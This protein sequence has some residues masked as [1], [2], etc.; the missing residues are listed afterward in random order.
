[1]VLPLL[2]ALVLAVSACQPAPVPA[3]S[4]APGEAA[5]DQGRTAYPH[6]DERIG[7]PRQIWDGVLK[8]DR[9][10]ATFRNTHRL[11]PTR[12]VSPAAQPRPL[13]AGPALT[14]PVITHDGRPLAFEELLEANR[15]AGLLVLKDGAVVLE[16]YRYGNTPQTRWMSMSVAKSVL[17]ALTGAALHDGRLA[18]LDEPVTRFVPVLQGSAYDGVTFDHLLRMASGVRFNEAYT[19]RTS[20]RRRMLE[21]QIAQRRGSIMGL[22]ASLPRDAEPGTRVQYSTGETQVLAGAARRGRD[23]AGD[24]LEQRIWQPAGME[25]PALWWLD[26]PDGTEIGGSGLNATLRDYGRFGQ[27]ILEDGV[28]GETRVLPEGWARRMGR[29]HGML[30]GTEIPYGL[31]WWPPTTTLAMAHGAFTAEGIHGQFIHVDPVARVVIVQWGA[32]PKPQ[33]GEIV[34]DAEV[35]DALVEA[36]EGLTPVST[37]VPGR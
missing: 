17:A 22:M 32:R 11:F 2:A 31:L 13:P 21:L 33:G 6:A 9:A 20:D 27:F 7:K 26:A 29:A 34:P 23:A 18:S 16:R 37:A 25:A 1:M 10:V 30:E 3:V 8:P 28:A 15:I 19:D 5:S 4:G 35:F 12:V 24:D 36:A 14:P